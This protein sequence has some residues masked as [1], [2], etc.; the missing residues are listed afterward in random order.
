MYLSPSLLEITWL[1]G[2]GSFWRSVSWCSFPFWISEFWPV[3]LVCVCRFVAISEFQ[4]L[5]MIRTSFA[6]ANSG[7]WSVTFSDAEHSVWLL[8]WRASP[9]WR[10]RGDGRW[11]LPPYACGSGWRDSDCEEFPGLW[12]R[13]LPDQ[14]GRGW[15][16]GEDIDDC[17]TSL[18][19]FL[20][21]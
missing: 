9:W 16:I 8:W 3:V 15:V 4:K 14:G 6:D 5:I 11:P 21:K 20:V 19:L 1:C 17:F 12:R 7:R 18:I 10:G 2:F 13:S